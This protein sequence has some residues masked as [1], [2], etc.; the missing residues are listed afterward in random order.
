MAGHEIWDNFDGAAGSNPNGG[1]WLEDTVN[2][3]GTQVYDPA[4]S[5]LDGNGHAVFEATRD[6]GGTIRSG[7]FTSRTKFNMQYGWVA[8]RIKFPNSSGGV[9][10]SWFPAFW[11]LHINYGQSG[12]VYGEQDMQEMFGDTT[13]YHAGLFPGSESLSQG[14]PVPAN[15]GGNAANAFHT[16]WMN[17]T[18]DT[19]QVGVDDFSIKTWSRNDLSN[20]ANWAGMQSP[21]Y[22]ILNFAVAPPWLPA[23]VASDFPARMQIDWIWYKP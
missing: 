18:P 10:R 4:R 5:F 15:H 23:P 12:T 2:Q 21:H 22:Y 19:I 7:R 16:Y 11:T 3:G 13:Q 9:G 14:R 8:A 6:S 20:P 1:L 17:W